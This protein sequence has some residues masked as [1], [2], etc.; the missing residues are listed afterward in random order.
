MNHFYKIGFCL[1]SFFLTTSCGYEP[2]DFEVEKPA[3]FALQEE[4]D[5][6]ADLKTFVNREA[7]PGFKLGTGAIITDYSLQ[8]VLYRL[9]NRNFDEITPA[10]GMMHGAIVQA[11]GSLN[12]ENVSKFL[13]T[14]EKAG[15]TVFG[16][17]LVSHA[18]QN[19]SYLNGLLTPL[20]V[21]SP[22]YANSLNTNSLKAG[23]FDGYST[24]GA[25]VLIVD[26]EGMGGNVKAIKLVSGASASAPTDLQLVTPAV[27]VVQGHEY[28]VVFYIKSDAPG[29]G[30]VAFEGLKNNTPAKDWTGTGS[31]PTFTT[32]PGWK[33]VRFKVNDFDAGSIKLH[34]DLGYAPNVTYYVDINNF[35]VYDTQG[36]PLITNLVANGNF[37]SGSGWGGWGNGSTRGITA[38]GMGLNNAG[39]AF[40]VT[41][42]SVAANYYTV[43][44]SYELGKPL[45]N[46]K[47]YKLSFWVKGTATG[48]IR[49]ELQS[50][51][52]SSNGFGMVN[53]TKDWQLVSLTTTA[54]AADRSRLVFS[55]GEFA[56]TVYIDDVV[57]STAISVGGTTLVQK[58]A[59]EKEAIIT[60][61]LDRWISGLVTAT[62]GSVKAWDVV[63]EPMDDE[64]PSEL[65][66]GK[67]RTLASDEFYWQD[68]LGK[69]YAVK[70][71]K[72][73][74]AKGNATDLLFINDTKLEQ[75]LDKTRGLI[76]Y[77]KYIEAN[78]AKV[79]GIGTRLNLSLTSDKQNITTMFQLLAATG[80]MVRVSGLSVSLGVTAD[81][82]TPEQYLAQKEMYQYVLNEY[83]KTVPAKQRYGVT[84]SNPLDT[85]EPAGLWTQGLV[86]KPA[87][88]GFA[89]GLKGLK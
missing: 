23:T 63:S 21:E 44:T 12:L 78:G 42:P 65:R 79:D 68:Y 4:I 73:A 80:K 3:S 57:L 15:M 72:A 16:H 54:T 35:Y 58:T 19:A 74:R 25:S 88:A 5:A 64:K 87:Y 40:F 13:T 38:D 69:E 6:Y 83:I 85:T 76:E 28:E 77:V 27:P 34:L 8:G 31:S 62:K 84:I 53:V 82:A 26:N 75:N 45:D 9:I 2:L 89:E 29:Q 48:V 61:Q 10:S 52:Y 49:P 66:T 81:K 39:K 59:A 36:D 24:L 32:G 14:A 56:G 7:N 47:A 41:N 71:F 46:G 60:S 18:N 43:Q 17:T 70:A 51:N 1:A 37:E 30:R 50:P 20:V 67:G 11:D 55:Y 86:R 33:R 22:A